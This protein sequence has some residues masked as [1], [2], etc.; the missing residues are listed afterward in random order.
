[1]TRTAQIDAVDANSAAKHLGIGRN[2]LL[3]LLRENGYTHAHAPRRNLPKKEFRAAG[4]FK[5]KLVQ[6]QQGPVVKLHEKLT[7]T[8]AGMDICRDLVEEKRASNE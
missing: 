5:T 1:M 4:L 6:F 3:A 2:T 7:I 8:A